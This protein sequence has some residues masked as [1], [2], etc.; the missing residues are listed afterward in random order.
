M[1]MFSS[2]VTPINWSE[3]AGVVAEALEAQIGVSTR[4]EKTG[5]INDP[6]GQ[7]HTPGR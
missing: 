6:L 7:A 2:A 1:E 4:K 3:V 5:V